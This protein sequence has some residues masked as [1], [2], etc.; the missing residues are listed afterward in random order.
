M[1]AARALPSRT[2]FNARTEANGLLIFGNTR[3]GTPLMQA[4]RTP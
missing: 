1:A 2:S 4:D 3:V